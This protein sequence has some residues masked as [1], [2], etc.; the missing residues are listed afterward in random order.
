MFGRVR[1][2][3]ATSLELLESERS[4]CK[5]IKH[6][7]LSIYESTLLKLKQGSQCNPKEDSFTTDDICIMAI[8]SPEEGMT[9]GAGCSST[10]SLPESSSS[11]QSTAYSNEEAK[12]NMSILH[13][14][15]KQKSATR[16]E[17]SIDTESMVIETG[18]SSSSSVSPVSSS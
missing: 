9:A 8:D 3:P 14:F 11:I 15:S 17:N 6:D 4:H 1:A 13:F 2:S 16:T 18:Y 7:S 10:E 12:M 5:I